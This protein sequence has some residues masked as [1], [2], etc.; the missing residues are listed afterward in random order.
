VFDIEASR[1]RQ[2]ENFSQQFFE[3]GYVLLQTSNIA[4]LSN[5]QSTW[6]KLS[7]I[8]STSP[9]DH[10]EL[11]FVDVF[12]HLLV[13]FERNRTALVSTGGIA[14]SKL[15]YYK[16]ANV[17]T[18]KMFYGMILILENFKSRLTTDI[19][20]IFDHY[21]KIEGSQLPLGKQRFA[22]IFNC[23]KPT[24]YEFDELF[25]IL[26]RNFKSCWQGG[27][28][29]CVDESIFAFAPSKESKRRAEMED[30]DPIPVVYIPIRM[31]YWITSWFVNQTKQD[32]LTLLT[33]FPIFDS[34]WFPLKS[35]SKEWFKD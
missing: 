16:R 23:M 5:E 12:E 27:G 8:V 28:P 9:L 20:S 22:A 29:I 19:S 26:T 3:S 10:F 25:R 33:L 32:F 4:L 1:K 34:Q 17:Q 13:I 30:R 18:I 7:S 11:I 2:F 15:K 31:G 6:G 14:K 21:K 24:N 35:H